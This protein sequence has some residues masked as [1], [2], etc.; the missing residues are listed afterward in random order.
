MCN[1]VTKSSYSV[2]THASTSPSL[3]NKLQFYTIG[4][5]NT[6]RK[7]LSRIHKAMQ[8]HIWDKNLQIFNTKICSYFTLQG[9]HSNDMTR[10]PNDNYTY[11]MLNHN[12]NVTEL[13]YSSTRL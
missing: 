6:K 1:W 11:V 4:V 12:I 7:L 13:K 2:K 10:W 8:V 3:I 9:M 5:L